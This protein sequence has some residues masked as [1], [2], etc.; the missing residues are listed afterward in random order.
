MQARKA[1]FQ[2]IDTKWELKRLKRPEKRIAQGK[3]PLVEPLRIG[4]FE[5]R[6]K[7]LEKGAMIFHDGEVKIEIPLL[8]P[9]GQ[10]K[11]E[12]LQGVYKTPEGRLITIRAEPAS[13]SFPPTIGYNYLEKTPEGYAEKSMFVGA[14][15]GFAFRTEDPGH[16]LLPDKD[17]SGRSLG[18]KAASKTEREQRARNAGAHA[19]T[20]DKRFVGLYRSLGYDAES[21]ATPFARYRKEGRDQPFDDMDKYHRIEAIDPK[22]GKARIFTFT[23]EQPREIKP[24]RELMRLE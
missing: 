5:E 11:T 4:D 12:T 7:A 2:D 20:G 3:K 24:N 8:K 1:R 23:V 16:M 13:T 17:L 19:F 21:T 14:E 10:G 6:K 18:K 9:A 15:F 22:T